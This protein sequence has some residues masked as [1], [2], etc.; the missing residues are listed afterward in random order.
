MSGSLKLAGILGNGMVIQ[1][2]EP[3]RIWGHDD[4][5]DVVK[6]LFENKTY[7]GK[8]EN[9]RFCIELP[10]HPYGTGYKITVEGSDK[11]ELDD[12][13]FGD[14]YMLA[15]QSNMELPVYRTLD[16]TEDEVKASNYPYIRQYRLTPQ[17]RLDDTKEADLL[18]LP[19]VKAVP[20]EIREISAVGFFC[21]KSLYEERKI[22]IG[23]VLNAQGGSTL[24]AWMPGDLL[25]EFKDCS[26]LI[27]RFIKDD[28]LQQFLKGKEKDII[29]WR[30]SITE[31]NFEQRAKSIPSDATEVTLP[32]I[33]LERE[34]NGY[35]GSLWLYKEVDIDVEPSKD[36]FLY[37]GELIDAD[38]TFI[39]GTM[40]GR[41]EYCYPP[42][43]YPFDGSILHKG[44]NLI[45]VR[46]EINNKNGGFLLDHKYYIR[47]GDRKIS[48]E[49][50]WLRK[51]EIETQTPA[52]AVIMGQTI[53]TAL[54]TASIRPILNLKFSGIWWYQG[55]SNADDPYNLKAKPGKRESKD[56]SYDY[57]FKA[58]VER[59]RK[60]LDQDLP[61]V[62][63]EMPDY[64]NPVDGLGDGWIELQKM[65]RN[66]PSMV[67]KCGV[68]FAKGLGEPYELHPQNKSVLGKLMA[69]EVRKL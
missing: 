13:C 35:T 62:V 64:V 22:P 44:K 55:E 39:N 30:N 61:I 16:V 36:S 7:E 60:D 4:N 32:G 3:F 15:G 69:D 57:L 26:E 49:G 8:T 28:S 1:R 56:I 65:Q 20:D 18:D 54:Y 12:I 29:S 37:V 48:L 58:M 40:V 27:N 21:A 9:G 38:Q 17:Y 24:E 34:G 59:W 51:N 10:S 47:T 52:P 2:D 68:V 41:T 31:E 25:A 50:T 63:V 33:F 14:V 23:L 6:V 45:A 43:K 19:W 46:L 42:R 5:S 66:A 11:V 67:D 53:P